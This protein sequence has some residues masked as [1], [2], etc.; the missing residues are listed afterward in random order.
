VENR[1]AERPQQTRGINAFDK[2]ARCTPTPERRITRW[3][4]E[5]V[6][7]AMQS[8]QC[9]LRID[10]LCRFVEA[11]TSD[12]FVQFV[13]RYR[14]HRAAGKLRLDRS[15]EPRLEVGSRVPHLGYTPAAGHR[16]V[17]MHDEAFAVRIGPSS[18]RNPSI[19]SCVAPG[20]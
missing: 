2:L 6:L 19:I 11:S 8:R 17:R 5:H 16:P 4:H 1:A 13:E 10:L 18:G 15:L 14:R 9:R 20:M 12:D 3:E 7:D